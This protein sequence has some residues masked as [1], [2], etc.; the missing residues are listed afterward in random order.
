[1][2]PRKATGLAD[3]HVRLSNAAAAVGDEIRKSVREFC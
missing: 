3:A 1:M 2:R